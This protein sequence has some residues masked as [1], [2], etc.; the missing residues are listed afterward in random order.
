M[1]DQLS[2][3][4]VVSSDRGFVETIERVKGLLKTEGFGILSEIDVA[5]TL[6]EKID[7]D[8]RPYVILGACNPHL[9]ARGL[10]AEEQLGLLLPCN[11]VVQE[12]NGKVAVSA[13]DASM[14]LGVVQNP[15]LK[16][17]ALDA[18]ARLQRVLE[19]VNAKSA[20]HG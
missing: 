13:V 2:Y 17:L 10:A 16:D 20:G 6:K 8:F 14:M 9:A 15:A 12:I 11:V 7:A 4:H 3:G 18:D 1:N 5:R 19:S